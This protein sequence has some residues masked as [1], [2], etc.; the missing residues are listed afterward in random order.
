MIRNTSEMTEAYSDLVEDD[1]T[2]IT[3][4]DTVTHD[5]EKWRVSRVNDSHV[6]IYQLSDGTKIVGIGEV[7]TADPA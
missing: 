6:E 3:P 4:G 1:G 5:G 7:A 2:S